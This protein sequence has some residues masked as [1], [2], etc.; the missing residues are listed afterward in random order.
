MRRPIGWLIEEP[1]ESGSLAVIG[2]QPSKAW[3]VKLK[4]LDRRR[5]RLV[6]VW[7]IL[8]I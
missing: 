3:L 8:E 7:L 4:K 6:V 5:L 1:G 2:E